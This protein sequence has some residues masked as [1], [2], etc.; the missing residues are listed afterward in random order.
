MG[1]TPGVRLHQ[2][3]KNQVLLFNL[4]SKSVGKTKR[5]VNRR[6][7]QSESRVESQ[8]EKGF[9]GGT[10]MRRRW[11]AEPKVKVNAVSGLWGRLGGTAAGGV[12]NVALRV[13]VDLAC[14]ICEEAGV[15]ICKLCTLMKYAREWKAQ[16]GRRKIQKLFKKNERKHD[17]DLH[18]MRISCLIVLLLT[19]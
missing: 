18:K 9:F 11:Q 12:A 5:K 8:Q 10:L 4:H 2:D 3:A 7:N 6:E 14:I 17:G 1:N 13:F 15:K 19:N 16:S